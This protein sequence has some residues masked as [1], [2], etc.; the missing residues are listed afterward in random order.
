M[1]STAPVTGSIA[2]FALG[3]ELRD[4]PAAEVRRATRLLADTLGCAVAARGEPLAER[5]A[6]YARRRS[7]S[8]L[9]RATLLA[10]RG[11]ANPALAALASGTAVRMLDANDLY[12]STFGGRNGGHLS[13][14]IPAILG[15]AEIA[16]STG[17]ETLAAIVA[18]YETQALL[19]DAVDWRARGWHPSTYVIW[20]VPAPVARLWRRPGAEAIAAISLAGSTG[21]ALQSWLRPDL[22]V[23][24]IKSVAPGLLGQRAVEAV[25]LACEGITAP[26]DALETMLRLLGCPPE[27]VPVGRLGRDWTLAR[28]LVKRYP[29]QYLTQAAVQGALELYAGGL[30]AE[31]VEA[32]TIYGHA[33]VCGSVQGAPH[34]YQPQ[35]QE[36]ADHSTPFVVVMAL[37]N[38][39]LRPTDYHGDPWLRPDVR[40]LMARVRLVEEPERQRAY[41][42]RGIIGCRLSVRQRDGQTRSADVLQPAG[43]PDAP[44]DD[45][46]LVAKLDEIMDGRLGSNGGARLLEVCARLPGAGDLGELFDLLRVPD[47]QRP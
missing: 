36:D 43:H 9:P 19:A 39:R 30:R 24:A 27:L 14:A 23:T 34:A 29:A 21:Q 13:D 38:G 26:P 41:L 2:A 42:E 3:L 17:A 40:A 12:C 15:A 25:E 18:A 45:D 31:R 8:E 11:T 46:A 47:D 10:A 32:V 22:P 44:L 1:L 37:L 6:A 16:G 5:L 33:G 20:A 28:N 4:V 35:S 7:S